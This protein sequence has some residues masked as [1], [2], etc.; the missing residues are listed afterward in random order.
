MQLI[1]RIRERLT[2]AGL[3]RYMVSPGGRATIDITH[4]LVSK[5]FALTWLLRELGVEG[6]ELRGEPMGTNAVYFGDE[7][8]LHGNDLP[9]AD[10][11][12][13]L[14]FAVNEL[15]ERVPFRSNVVIPTEFTSRTGPE[16]TEAVLKDLMAYTEQLRS[17]EDIGTRVW[18]GMATVAM[19]KEDRMRRT[20]KERCA[21]LMGEAVS[22]EPLSAKATFRRLEAA[23]AALTA[24][25]RR[26]D[27][28]DEL[29]DSI[30]ATVNRIGA[31]SAVVQEQQ[32]ESVRPQGFWRQVSK[33]TQ[34]DPAAAK[35]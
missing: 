25:T 19:W 32:F 31:V 14:V 16:A 1:E 26:G 17:E 3:V 12:G 5:R 13:I 34:A 21:Y 29:A 27:G 23:A 33:P 2:E 18:R 22:T 30:I 6:V 4:H 35:S 9:V 20:L 15:R 11:P 8:V 10:I 28:L 7:V 24:L